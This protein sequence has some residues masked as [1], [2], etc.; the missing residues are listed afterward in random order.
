M[1]H[2]IYVSLV[3]PHLEYASKIW[4]PHLTGGILVLE[5]V[6]KHATKL[7]QI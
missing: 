1:F 3:C 6:Q 2:T 5:K 4:N 7:V